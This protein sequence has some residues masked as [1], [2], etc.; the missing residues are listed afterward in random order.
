MGHK[1]L[2]VRLCHTC[3]MNKG[4]CECFLQLLDGFGLL[5]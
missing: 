2:E 5:Q 1:L 3:T 4:M